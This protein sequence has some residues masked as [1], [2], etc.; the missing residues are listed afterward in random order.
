MTTG[1]FV[2]APVLH[3]DDVAQL[4]RE[5]PGARLPDVRTPGEDEKMHSACGMAMVSAKLPYNRPTTCDVDTMVRALSDGRAP[6]G[7]G[8]APITF[9]SAPQTC[10]S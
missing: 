8:R 9:G 4:G 1:P 6:A 3:P 10:T 7:L 5:H 2:L